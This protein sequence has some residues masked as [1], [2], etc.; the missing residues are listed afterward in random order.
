[1]FR[2]SFKKDL[3]AGFDKE[4]VEQVCLKNG[5]LM[6]GPTGGPTRSERLPGAKNSTRVYR[7]TSKV[8]EGDG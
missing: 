4:L 1:M 2:E 6:P 3:C 7:F 5:L 8:M